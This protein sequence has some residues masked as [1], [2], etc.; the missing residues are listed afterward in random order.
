MSRIEKLSIALT[1]EL[2]AEVREAV[3]GGGYASASE[4]VRE[5][6]RAWSQTRKAKAL[7]TADLRRAWDQ[8]LASGDPAERRP[9]EEVLKSGRAKLAKARAA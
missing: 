5:A 1:A 2:A 4:V 9:I 6:L 3:R 7:A 8:G